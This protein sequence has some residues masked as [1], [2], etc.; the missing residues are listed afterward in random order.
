MPTRH[1]PGAD[2]RPAVVVCRAAGGT[3]VVQHGAPA[4]IAHQQPIAKNM[5]N[6]FIEAI[7][8]SCALRGRATVARAC[9]LRGAR[10]RAGE[11][12]ASAH[13]A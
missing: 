9:P 8:R 5:G 10:A 12:A 1:R 11:R 13:R 3:S 7:I 6:P 2:P 4:P